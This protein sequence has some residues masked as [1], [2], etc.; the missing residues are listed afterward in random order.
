M[1]CYN[2]ASGRLSGAK[3][4]P[5]WNMKIVSVGFICLLLPTAA[6]GQLTARNP[7]DELKDQVTQ[8]LADAGVPFTP[9]Q[10]KQLALLIPKFGV[11]DFRIKKMPRSH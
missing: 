11:Q 2:P 10:E 6:F 9:D 7:V 1:S 3:R 8:A 4:E 5:G